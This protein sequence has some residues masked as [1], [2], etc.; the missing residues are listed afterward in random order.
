MMQNQ[1]NDAV[2]IERLTA[3]KQQLLADLARLIAFEQRYGVVLKVIGSVPQCAYWLDSDIDVY[4]DASALPHRPQTWQLFDASDNFDLILHPNDVFKQHILLEGVSPHE[5]RYRLAGFDGQRELIRHFAARRYSK[6]Q[7]T[8]D[9]S[10]FYLAQLA[11][12]QKLCL[13]QTGFTD[14]FAAG[15]VCQ[16]DIGQ[17]AFRFVWLSLMVLSGYEHWLAP[18]GH[19]MQYR[20]RVEDWQACYRLLTQPT[21]NRAAFDCPGAA[22]VEDFYRRLTDQAWLHSNGD[23]ADVDP[24]VRLNAWQQAFIDFEGY[25]RRWLDQNWAPF[26]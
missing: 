10:A 26:A 22:L 7:R 24:L 21:T 23:G 13:A 4:V 3:K 15:V 19:E 5:A 11:P 17:V 12:L 25:T 8:L 20:L 18:K 16:P 9:N 6:M 14:A 2:L 1:V